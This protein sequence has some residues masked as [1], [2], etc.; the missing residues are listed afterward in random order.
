M[1]TSGDTITGYT[2]DY[3][4]NGALRLVGA[5]SPPA[6]PRPEHVSKTIEACNMMLKTWQVQNLLWLREFATVFL[7]KG[8][9]KYFLGPNSTSKGAINYYEDAIDADLVATDTVITVEDS[10]NMTAAD[11]IGIKLD[12]NT[13][14]WDTIASVDSAT[15]V[16]ITTG[17]AGAATD[18]NFLYN[19]PTSEALYRPTRVFAATRLTRTGQEIPIDDD[20]LLSRSDYF[21][22]TNKD[23]QGT[24]TQI[25]FDKQRSTGHL[26]VWST[27]DNNLDRLVL[28][29]DRQIQLVTDT[30]DEYDFPE[31]WLEPIKYGLAVR[32]APE[33]AV[34]GTAYNIIANTFS[35]LATN[36]LG[37]EIEHV[38]A[39]I[40]VQNG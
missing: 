1:P 37:F 23:T 35:G 38:N 31:E 17:V 3:V 20:N 18:G 36:V 34:S 21:S 30:N 4:I 14:H 40:G 5:Y 11:I 29:L 8:Q 33:H 15:Q 13:I 27:S 16:T 7:V 39:M 6:D 28:D 32:I 2:R 12:D 25:Y 26:Y 9:R 19:Y 22:L 10:S 24:V